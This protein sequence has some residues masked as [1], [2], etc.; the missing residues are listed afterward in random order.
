MEILFERIVYGIIAIVLYIFIVT[1]LSVVSKRCYCKYLKSNSNNK[2]YKSKLSFIHILLFSLIFA[3]YNKLLT[4]NSLQNG[5]G[6]DR[7]N[8]RQDFFGRETGYAG[9][10]FYDELIHRFTDNFNL[11]MYITT[12]VCCL[13]LFVAYNLHQKMGSKNLVFLMYTPV[14]F[15]SFV[16]Y[17]QSMSC[18]FVMLFFATM[19]YKASWKRNIFAI[20]CIIISCSFH[21]S[22][23]LLIPLFFLIYKDRKYRLG[24][25]LII[26]ITILIF[27]E[28]LCRWIANVSSP[29]LPILS[30]KLLEYFA[31][32]SE[33]EN[34]GTVITVLKGF[35]YYFLV[36]IGLLRRK[37][38]SEITKNYDT[39]LVLTMI[40]AMS[41]AIS[42]IS[43]W[44]S[45]MT[46]LFYL[47]ASIFALMVIENEDNPN[48]AFFE[49]SIYIG[50]I[51]FFTFRSVFLTFYNYG[52]Y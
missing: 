31:E 22:A 6:A 30:Q 17:K 43:Y 33:H 14:V 29:Y 44:L 19:S 38:T 2:R 10:D 1:W 42:G 48:L 49:K 35:P 4:E 50:S 45:R 9:Y 37:K 47:P 24:L 46:A 25:F 28:P 34:D 36:L 8:Y 12:F 40:A 16:G 39:Y 21:S 5:L 32:G 3:V 7:S 26:L 41:C 23:Y 18:I 11:Y 52:G 15:Y 13:G 27:F 51:S 20:M